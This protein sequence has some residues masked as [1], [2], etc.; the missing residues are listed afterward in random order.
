[1]PIQ[2]RE[3]SYYYKELIILWSSVTNK[4]IGNGIDEFTGYTKI[5]NLDLTVRIDQDIGRLHV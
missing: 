2:A 1:M 4:C 3:V 5:A